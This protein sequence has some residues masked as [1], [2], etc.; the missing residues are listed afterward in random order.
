MGAPPSVGADFLELT[1]SYATIALFGGAFPPAAALALLA[2][3][4]ESR[5]DI[6]KYL[7]CTQ[8]PVPQPLG[9]LMAK[10]GAQ[11][12]INAYHFAM[13]ADTTR[14][15]IWD[16]AGGPRSLR[17]PSLPLFTTRESP[18]HSLIWQQRRVPSR[19]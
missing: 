2:N 4:I 15:H 17:R 11:L 19:D 13:L 5:T 16:R 8:R 18:V 6:F 3:A 7:R 9:A 10:A 14:C 12:T 1:M